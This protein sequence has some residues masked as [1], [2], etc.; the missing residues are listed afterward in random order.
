MRGGVVEVILS[1]LV[2]FFAVG[3]FI[4][5]YRYSGLAP[6]GGYTVTAQFTSVGGLK[7]GDDVEVAGVV[8]GNV[9][10]VSIDPKTYRAIV[11]IKLEPQIALPVDTLA[12]VSGT[13]LAGKKYL[14]LQPGSSTEMIRPGGEVTR[15]EGSQEIE[16]RLGRY[17]FGSES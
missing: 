6:S 7:P 4:F 5:A 13:T 14:K 17:I 3:F 16:Q 11:A 10:S 1:A 9:S 15:T 8:V 2:L 12:V